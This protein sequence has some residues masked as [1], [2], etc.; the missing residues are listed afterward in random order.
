MKNKCRIC[1]KQFLCKKINNKAP[2]SYD[3]FK[4]A[5]ELG[6]NCKQIKFSETKNYGEVKYDKNK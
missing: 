1:I 6:E 4:T 2:A 5:N 3:I